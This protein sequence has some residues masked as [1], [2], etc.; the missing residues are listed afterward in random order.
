MGKLVT[1]HDIIRENEFRPGEN[2]A[3]NILACYGKGETEDGSCWCLIH[4]MEEYAEGWIG[5][6]YRNGI[7]SSVRN[8]DGPN[9]YISESLYEIVALQLEKGYKTKKVNKVITTMVYL[10]CAYEDLLT[11]SY[12]MFDLE[13]EALNF[14]EY[15]E[16]KEISLE[17]FRANN[18]EKTKKLLLA[19]HRTIIYKMLNGL[20]RDED[21]KLLIPL[22]CRSLDDE[23]IRKIVNYVPD[24]S[25]LLNIDLDKVDEYN[26]K[27]INERVKLEYK[28][29]SMS[30][31]EQEEFEI[32]RT[33]TF[34]T[35]TYVYNRYMKDG[36]IFLD[37]EINFIFLKDDGIK[38]SLPE[39]LEE[40]C[41]FSK[42]VQYY[43]YKGIKEGTIELKPG[44]ILP[45]IN[46]NK[47]P[48]SLSK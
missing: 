2:M 46:I 31:E 20:V 15:Y 34:L 7:I 47:R 36:E 37:Y 32:F 18:Y 16:N 23:I 44:I 48:S 43:V 13:K 8:F 4:G 19:L 29:L 26:R 33:Y 17:K 24:T 41:D 12:K 45:G 22:L 11:E 27:S 40:T 1:I 28:I 14:S 39:A 21:Y 6:K 5:K 10:I 3:I 42:A 30:R 25:V 9:C 35:A 38:I